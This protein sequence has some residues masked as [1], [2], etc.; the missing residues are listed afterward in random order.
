MLLRQCIAPS[1]NVGLE[2]GWQSDIDPWALEEACYNTCNLTVWF[3]WKG[4]GK[5]TLKV[6]FQGSWHTTKHNW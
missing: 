5:V 6:R 3:K 1:M 2:P 4:W